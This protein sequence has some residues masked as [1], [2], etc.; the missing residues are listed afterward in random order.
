MRGHTHALILLGGWLLMI[1]PSSDR[2]R[3][4]NVADDYIQMGAFD[5]AE[6]CEVERKRRVAYIL[7][8]ID[9]QKAESAHIVP[10]ELAII[11]AGKCLPAEV[12]YPPKEPA[13]K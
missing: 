1:P 9:R 2:P 5:T 6:K 3:R 11:E 10:E 7:D 8:G 4:G 12:V 13:Q